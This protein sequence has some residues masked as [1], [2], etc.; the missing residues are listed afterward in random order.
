M[1]LSRWFT[2]EEFTTSQTAE[3]LGIDNTPNEAAIEAMRHLCVTVLDRVRDWFDRP[4]VIS[5]GYRCLGLNR[6]IGS[7]DG[8]QHVKGEAADIVVPSRTLTEVFNYIAASLDYDQMIREFP[9]KG[10]IHVSCVDR[11]RKSLL[12][13]TRGSGGQTIYTPATLPLT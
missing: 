12:V 5:S 2:L 1:K 7:S 11:N 4:V 6:A 10:W 3:R 9:P 13:A 8:S